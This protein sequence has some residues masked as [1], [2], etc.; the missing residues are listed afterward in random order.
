MKRVLSLLILIMLSACATKVPT[1]IVSPAKK[2]KD[3]VRKIAVLPFT[4]MSNETSNEM[5][6]AELES[7]LAS[8]IYNEEP[9]FTLSERRNVV[10]LLK[11]LKFSNSGHVR[12]KDIAKLGQML[13]VEGV[14][15]GSVTAYKED[16]KSYSKKVGEE[17][18]NCTTYTA[19]FGM[20]PRLIKVETAEI[21]YAGNHFTTKGVE[22]CKG[23]NGETTQ[24]T[25]VKVMGEIICLLVGEECDNR[26]ASS[27]AEV[28]PVAKEVVFEQI[29]QDI[30]PSTRI[31]DIIL[32]DDT[33]YLSERDKHMFEGALAF[34]DAGRF[35]DRSCPTFKSMYVENFSHVSVAHNT[36]VCFEKEGDYEKA[37]EI[38]DSLDKSL[39]APHDGVNDL[40]FRLREIM[41]NENDLSTI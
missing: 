11:E 24:D 34:A 32:L 30:A 33:E 14:I 1:E 7:A 16:E 23:E 40:I 3:P 28:M 2:L 22:V 38:V 19:N 10:G 36:A 12:E 5:V 9:Y 39:T 41:R 26:K 13:G 6:T 27:P 21:I 29:S 17:F 8:I 18:Q 20:S 31:E 37:Y 15:T 25:T 4:G 35:I